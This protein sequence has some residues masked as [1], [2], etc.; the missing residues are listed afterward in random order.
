MVGGRVIKNTFYINGSTYRLRLEKNPSFFCFGSFGANLG[1]S[2]I[3]ID[4]NGNCFLLCSFLWTVYW[5]AI[6]LK[7]NFFIKNRVTLL[8]PA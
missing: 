4:P 2:L 8:L 6:L 3:F 7:I 5:Q 1:V